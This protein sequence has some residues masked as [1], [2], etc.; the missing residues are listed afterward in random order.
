[1]KKQTRANHLLK[2]IDP[3]TWRALT[4]YAASRGIYEHPRRDG[5]AV[6]HRDSAK[7]KRGSVRGL[8]EHIATGDAL[9]VLLADDLE[10]DLSPRLRE[11]AK[12]E[13]STM[14]TDLL[15]RIAAALDDAKHLFDTAD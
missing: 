1:M 13:T 4:E 9:F 10:Y 2:N 7:S 12:S 14:T 5:L 15:N 11:I 6:T 3:Q 8:L